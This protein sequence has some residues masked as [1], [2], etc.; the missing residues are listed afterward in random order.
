[1][2]VLGQERRP[3][4]HHHGQRELAQDRGRVGRHRQDP[5][6]RHAHADAPA[7]LV[8]LE[9]VVADAEG[10]LVQQVDADVRLEVGAVF[11][12]RD[13]GR[14]VRRDDEIE[15]LAIAEGDQGTLPGIVL[16]RIRRQLVDGAHV[17]RADGH[18]LRRAPGDVDVD[19]LAPERT[20]DRQEA[21][22]AL[23]EDEDL[24]PHHAAA[25]V[26]ARAGEPRISSNTASTARAWRWMSKTATPP[27][28]A[29]WPL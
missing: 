25:P 5:V 23:P 26:A 2:Q 20:D 12:E 3:R 9:L 8:A 21:R 16:G 13:D 6:A 24:P 29:A 27:A 18:L 1:A 28:R 14:I 7:Q 22:V 17:A 10:G 4:L 15:A 19:S 11:L